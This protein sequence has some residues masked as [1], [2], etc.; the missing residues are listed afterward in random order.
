MRELLKEIGFN[1]L[2]IM[3]RTGTYIYL[4]PMKRYAE[5]NNMKIG[6]RAIS[7]FLANKYVID[8]LSRLN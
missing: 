6:Y 3:L 7:E 2:L 8:W 5:L 1:N 4:V